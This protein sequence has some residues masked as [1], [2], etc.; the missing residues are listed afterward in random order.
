[1]LRAR[2]PTKTHDRYTEMTLPRIGF[3]NSGRLLKFQSRSA[4]PRAGGAEKLHSRRQTLRFVQYL[5][6]FT[7]GA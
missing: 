1:M 7:T 6:I 4:R 5:T 3:M 2:A